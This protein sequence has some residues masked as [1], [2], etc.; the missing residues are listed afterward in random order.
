M[1]DRKKQSLLNGALVLSLA[2]I[3]VKITGVLFKLYVTQKIGYTARGYFATA[4]NIYTPIYSIALAGLPT[5]VA[6][7]VAE[8]AAQG[9]YR[10]V[11]SLFSVSTGLFTLLGVLGTVV[12]ILLSYPYSLSVGSV[13]ALPA[14]LTVAPSLLFCCIMSGYR[15]YYQGLRNMNPSAVSQVIEAAGKLIF[16]FIF[17]NVVLTIGVE[18]A[19][20][21]PVLRDI[22]IDA[23][24]AYSAAAAI[25]GVTIGSVIALFYII[26]KRRFDKNTIP[27]ELYEASPESESRKALR[28]QL[29]ALALPI[30]LSSL[31][32][33][34]TTFIDSWTIQNR[35]LYVLDGNFGVI[36]DMYP[37]IIEATG[38]IA[39][40]ADELKSY[41]FGAYDTVL[42]IKNII[43]TFT[44]TL[45]LSAIP[46]LSEAWVRKDKKA[47][48]RAISSV[49]RLTMLISLPAGLGLFVLAKE[50]LVLIYGRNMNT[51]PA[52]DDIAPILMAYGISVCFLALAQ[53]VTNMLQAVNRTDVPVKSMALGATVKIL[54]NFILV[55]I[56]TINIQGAV[57]GSFLCN[58]VMVIYGLIVLRKE[59]GSKYDIRTLLLKP[60]FCSVLSAVGAY[61]VN[62]ICNYL[63]RGYD[64]NSVLSAGNISTVLAVFAAVLI[65]AVSLLLTGSLQRSDI[66]MLPKGEK[67]AK[68]L[69]KYGL[70]G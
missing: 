12:I 64:I 21:I 16:G 59:T 62:G 31:V 60:L 43:P 70:L 65:Y 24:S 40:Q 19:E 8:K 41:L 30:A 54:A 55:S 7:L 25:S 33:N 27:K 53:P 1:A 56:P 47:A 57:V 37:K 52:I 63:M 45:G 42:E 23:S 13:N 15:G 58:L 28:K 20:S 49:L 68:V 39:S 17:M 61:A 66:R 22:V 44:I 3:I 5:A 4:Y 46:V 34:L 10:D 69:E 26:I 11:K 67:I 38:Y 50:I 6:K 18:F 9:R 2:V 29:L 35:L 32:F 48:G 51:A 14:V 36:A